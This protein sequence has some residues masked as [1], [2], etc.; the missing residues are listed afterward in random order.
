MSSQVKSSQ[1]KFA[2]TP[3]AP[4]ASRYHRRLRPDQ[5]LFGRFLFA[6]HFGLVILGTRAS[7]AGL[8][9]DARRARACAAL[10]MASSH[11]TAIPSRIGF[12]QGD[13]SLIYFGRSGHPNFGTRLHLFAGT[14]P[15]MPHGAH[16]GESIFDPFPL[17]PAPPGLPTTPNGCVDIL[18]II[19]RHVTT[20]QRTRPSRLARRISSWASNALMNDGI[21][22]ENQTRDGVV[23]AY[24]MPPA[25]MPRWHGPA[26][27]TQP[28]NAVPMGQA[29]AAE[30]RMPCHSQTHSLTRMHPPPPRKVDVIFALA[31]GNW[32]CGVPSCRK[33]L[34][35]WAAKGADDAMCCARSN[36]YIF[37]DGMRGPTAAD[38]NLKPEFCCYM[39]MNK[40]EF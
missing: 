8:L 19:G 32:H 30:P 15:L 13:S 11:A 24:P 20:S 21:S 23:R 37:H 1:V 27:L 29:S 40:G 10:L 9:A 36:N 3:T 17:H 25:Q 14:H 6:S 4:S 18:A 35:P 5:P 31:K 38:N 12:E 7:L 2:R 16:Q 22:Y 26:N 39:C 34:N 33:P 28:P